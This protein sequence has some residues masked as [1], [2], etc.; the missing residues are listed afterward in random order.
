MEV[1]TMTNLLDDACDILW[2]LRG[3]LEDKS[4]NPGDD[5]E[6]LHDQTLTALSLIYRAKKLSQEKVCS[7][8]NLATTPNKDA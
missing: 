2:E 4:S 3:A 6:A 8:N 1:K 7:L 5:R